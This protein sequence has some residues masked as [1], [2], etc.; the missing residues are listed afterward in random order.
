MADPRVKAMRRG[1]VPV[2]R[3]PFGDITWFISA[4]AGEAVLVPRNLK[5]QAINAGTVPAELLIAFSAADRQ[6]VL[7]EE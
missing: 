3:L 1:E 7:E 2:D 4:K 6:S 5:H